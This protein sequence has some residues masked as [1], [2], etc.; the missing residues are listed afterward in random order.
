MKK[1]IAFGVLALLVLMV[2]SA[3]IYIVNEDEVAV[4]KNLGKITS[5]VVNPGEKEIV[6]ANLVE[7]GMHNVTI[8]D[9]KGLHFKI[10]V[11]QTVEKYTAKYLTYTSLP[12]RVNTSDSRPVEVQMYAT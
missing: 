3:S 11:I 6:S 10:P 4:V 5:V 1:S 2:L 8:S 12:E 9:L 7:N